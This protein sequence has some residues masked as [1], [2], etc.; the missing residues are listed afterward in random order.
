MGGILSK[1]SKH[2]RSVA[3]EE[4]AKMPSNQT[5]PASEWRRI[6]LKRGVKKDE[7][8]YLQL[9]ENNPLKMSGDELK[10]YIQEKAFVPAEQYKKELPAPVW[11]EESALS[12][13]RAIWYDRMRRQLQ[14]QS[15]FATRPSL[16][17][18]RARGGIPDYQRVRPSG[19]LPRISAD[20]LE[21][22]LFDA[23]EE[24]E[25]Q[26]IREQPPKQTKWSQYTYHRGEGPDSSG[27]REMVL[28]D[29][30]DIPSSKGGNFTAERHWG[31]LKNPLLHVRATATP[32]GEYVIDE[33]QSDLHQRGYQK[34]YY[35]PSIS[36]QVG[37]LL[38]RQQSIGLLMDRELSE[39]MGEVLDLYAPTT[40][41]R[42]SERLMEEMG[43]GRADQYFFRGFGS[44]IDEARQHAAMRRD[45]FF[46][47]IA[48]IENEMD[49][50]RNK[51]SGPYAAPWKDNWYEKGLQRA[52][53]DAIEAGSD[54][55]L[56]TT[57]EVQRQRWPTETAPG[58]L[59]DTVIAPK[60]EKLAKQTGTKMEIVEGPGGKRYYQ[61]PITD[62]LREMA[63]KGWPAFMAG[64]VGV[65]AGLV[66]EDDA[67]AAF[68]TGLMGTSSKL[69]K[70]AARA[71]AGGVEPNEVWQRTGWFPDVNI[72]EEYRPWDERL[73]VSKR[74]TNL[75]RRASQLEDILL[76][77]VPD[78]EKET[79]KQQIIGRVDPNWANEEQAS[80]LAARYLDD[81]SFRGSRTQAM[82]LK[83]ATDRPAL[84]EY[85]PW[86]NQMRFIPYRGQDSAWLSAQK[87]IPTKRWAIGLSN[88]PHPRPASAPGVL[89]LP[90][91]Q[92]AAMTHEIAHASLAEAFP[93]RFNRQFVPSFER[94]LSD[95]YEYAVQPGEMLPRVS[96]MLGSGGVDPR[97]SPIRA[98][99][100]LYQDLRSQWR[101]GLGPPERLRWFPKGKVGLTAAGTAGVLGAGTAGAEQ[102]SH[103]PVQGEP[104]KVEPNGMQNFT[105]G[106]LAMPTGGAVD[107]AGMVYDSARQRFPFLPALPEELPGGW[108]WTTRQL[109]GDPNTNAALAG[110]MMPV[111][112][113]ALATRAGRAVGKIRKVAPK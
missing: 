31:R 43:V 47:E 5:L 3:L 51:E 61:L 100:V 76:R 101:P 87:G 95:P 30:R 27:Y 39:A 89:S 111:S 64:G 59:Y 14:R 103:Q 84:T 104:S 16:Q 2:W 94:L 72:G 48:A 42:P 6:L 78:W 21:D 58:R 113:G 19:I 80:R 79:T 81:P 53:S 69:K 36:E 98:A 82:A 52:I 26:F 105:A 74:R 75:D 54:R 7:L 66:P 110:G 109:G 37:E 46:R 106:V 44:Y 35:D 8:D 90:E 92:S 15:R 97:V 102:M 60:M 28:Q 45:P 83:D 77:V 112:V 17:I 50:L 108:D 56:V 73:A 32:R 10:A 18:G 62:K 38:K 67:E 24:I 20:V 65:L 1:V 107:I 99:D 57:G 33:L 22:S 9:S 49:E 12:E 13:A 29:P 86:A 91:Q 4:A 11:N 41:A 85:L 55:V 71:L 40:G 88:K 25:R 93:E 63:A 68:T 96:E 34:G 23:R 70:E